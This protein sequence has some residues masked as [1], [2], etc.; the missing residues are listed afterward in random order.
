MWPR[1]IRKANALHLN[2]RTRDLTVPNGPYVLT[3]R[4]S[5]KEEMRRVVAAVFDPDAAPAESVGFENHL[6]YF[7][8]C[9]APLDIEVAR[10]L[11]AYL[12]TTLV[13]EYF[14][15]FNG[16]TQVNATDLS[17]LA[18]RRNRLRVLGQR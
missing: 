6:N 7:H 8:R 3:K 14:R 1:P 13:D 10:G 12:N 2:E 9:G 5:A 16:H 11:A 17:S 18:I 4:F 15:Q